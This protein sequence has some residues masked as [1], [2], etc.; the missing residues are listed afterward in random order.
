[1]LNADDSE[2]VLAMRSLASVAASGSR[3]IVFWVGAGASK[4]LGYPLWKDLSLQLRKAFFQRVSGF[5]NH[6][7]ERLLNA[8]RYPELFQ[9]CRNLDS[10]HYNK[11]LVDIFKPRVQDGP[12]GTFVELLREINPLFVVTTNVDEALEKSL[13]AAVTV[14]RTDLS[15]CVDF[16]QTKTPFVAKL[17]G[18]I[19]SVRS[20]VF[21]TEDYSEL[22]SDPHYIQSLKYIFTGC[23]VVFLA[24]GV[25]DSYVVSLLRD[26]VAHMELFGAGPHFVVTN[27]P[28]PVPSLR[29]I[30]YLVKV[31]P[32]HSAALNVLAHIAQSATRTAPTTLDVQG[33]NSTSQDGAKAPGRVPPGK[34]A[35]YITDLLPGDFQEITAGREGTEIEASFGLGFTAEEMP[36]TA[37]TALHDITVALICFDYVYLPAGA[38]GLIFTLVGEPLFRELITGDVIRFI[39]DITR[40]GVFFSPH[41]AMGSLGN[42]T[43]RSK[44]GASA[45]PLSDVIRR[46]FS[47][48]AG[49]EVEAE[50]LFSDIERRTCVYRKADEIEFTS[51]VRGALLM[52]A[53]STLLGIGDCIL[54][55]QVPRWLRYPYLRL[56][57]L[58]QTAVLCGEYGIQAAKVSFGGIQ[59]TN[60]AFGVEPTG[61]SA[62][63]LASYVTAGAYNADLGALVLQNPP[64]VKQILHFR[65]SSAGQAFRAEIR[66]VLAAENGPE[67]NASVN[68]GLS[69]AIP[70][71]ILQQARDKMLTLMTESTRATVVPAVWGNVLYSD[72]VTKR[73]RD[74]SAK[75]LVELC[76]SR[77]ITKDDPC[78]CG[79][80]EKLRLCC[81]APLRH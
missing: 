60:A 69:R 36:F 8:E 58:V 4:W 66:Q 67:F 31:K 35:Y 13:P 59:L 54:P 14:Q 27:G 6:Q 41:Q 76:Q 11:F 32:D 49:K 81:M 26:N 15:R 53:V 10:G 63:H 74:R 61:N 46:S 39:H 16:L 7:A 42:A 43:A 62:D 30:R 21:T 3:P 5:D 45:R 64:I 65:D 47:P 78:I 34:T 23:T 2:S 33:P 51:L 57:H 40:L 79:S 38:L 1:M 29:R 24:Y 25:R 44:D 52:P 18:S 22:V 72:S 77:N 55:T 28:A 19:S 20:M 75:M 48:I 80:G 12:Y 68:A 71:T 56:G 73:W 50:K 17:H 9:I 70:V 37:S